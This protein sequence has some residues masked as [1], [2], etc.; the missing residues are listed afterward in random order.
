M[1]RTKGSKNKPK[2]PEAIPFD[3]ESDGNDDVYQNIMSGSV[4]TTMV[5]RQAPP[6]MHPTLAVDFNMNETPSYH[7]PPLVNGKLDQLFFIEGRVRLDVMGSPEPVFSEQKRL[8][9]AESFDDAVRKFSTYF[10]SLSNNS[11]RY[12]VIGA[13]GTEAIT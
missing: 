5:A 9:W 13:G 1:P 2:T 11:Q 4:P 6:S 3:Y 12:T 10:A 8:V 7:L